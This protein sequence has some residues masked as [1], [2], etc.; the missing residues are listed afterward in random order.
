MG[1]KPTTTFLGCFGCCFFPATVMAMVMT[2]KQRTGYGEP[3]PFPFSHVDYIFFA[4]LFYTVLLIL[5]I[6]GRR[7]VTA[8]VS[9]PLLV[10]TAVMAFFA[11]M[12]FSGNYL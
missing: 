9:I 11:G 8:L 10:V 5:L 4:D 7:T 1:V 2:Y 6:R 3:G 12:W